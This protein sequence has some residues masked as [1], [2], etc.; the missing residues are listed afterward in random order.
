[1]E[2]TMLVD[3]DVEDARQCLCNI[4]ETMYINILGPDISNMLREYLYQVEPWEELVEI[5]NSC[6]V[7]LDN[8]DTHVDV[9]DKYRQLLYLY[10]LRTE[11]FQ[12][13]AKKF[14]NPVVKEQVVVVEDVPSSPPPSKL[15]KGICTVAAG[16]YVCGVTYNNYH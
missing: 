9:T 10:C 14:N 2:C 12:D 3:E 8:S 13:I 15:V 1:M 7:E 6:I 4:A 11:G 5:F 16:I